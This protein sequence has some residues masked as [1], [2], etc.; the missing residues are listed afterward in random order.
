[1]KLNLTYLK[2]S[3]Y[4]LPEL[5][6]KALVAL[7]EQSS[8]PADIFQ[9]ST[10][11][12]S[13]PYYELCYDISVDYTVDYTVMCD[14]IERYKVGTETHD[15]VASTY[16]IQGQINASTKKRY[17]SQESN[18]T[19]TKPESIIKSLSY[20]NMV[21]IDNI[22]SEPFYEAAKTQDF[23][24]GMKSTIEQCA[25]DEL[26][27]IRSDANK[28]KASSGDRILRPNSSVT[29]TNMSINIYPISCHDIAIKYNDRIFVISTP[30]TGDCVSLKSSPTD[31]DVEKQ[32]NKSTVASI[33]GNL[34]TGN[35]IAAILLFPISLPYGM[36]MSSN[37]KAMQKHSEKTQ[38]ELLK[39]GISEYMRKN[40]FEPP[41]E[42]QTGNS[43]VTRDSKSTNF[44]GGAKFYK[45]LVAF[46]ASS[47]GG[48]GLHKVLTGKFHAAQI[49]FLTSILT[50]GIGLIPMT[51]I[52]IIECVIYLRMSDDDF[53]KTYME[54]SREWL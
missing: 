30:G 5:I 19:C 49:M 11:T 14:R 10:F 2:S 48:L 29:T 22:E 50:C 12:V 17:F 40:G 42:N 44:S 1:M 4:G 18:K 45:F 47:L 16:Q 23:S 37:L 13:S 52:A 6:S 39:T 36:M 31:P 53:V 41:V 35:K 38:S 21:R 7:T 26:D 20:Y 46:C 24:R 25:D 3:T 43:E 8:L 9:K 54:G 15:R 27:L 33:F 28:R 32:R 34:T 51:V